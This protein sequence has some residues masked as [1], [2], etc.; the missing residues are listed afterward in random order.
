ME[1]AARRIWLA[2]LFVSLCRYMAL[3]SMHSLR[4]SDGASHTP[5]HLQ[6]PYPRLIPQLVVSPCLRPVPRRCNDS[7]ASKGLHPTSVTNFVMCSMER[8]MS[9]VYRTSRVMIW[10]GS[11]TIWTKYVAALPF[12]TLRS[13]QR[14]L[15]MVSILPVPLHGSV[16]ANSEAFVAPARYF[17]HRAF[18]RLTF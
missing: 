10:F 18:F 17:Q 11:L 16:Y 3:P 12:P 5:S 15:S 1:Q 9:N 2:S 4:G 7:I 14:R 13:N 6:H 8:S